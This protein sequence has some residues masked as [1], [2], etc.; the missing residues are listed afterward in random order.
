MANRSRKSFTLKFKIF[1][2][3][4]PLSVGSPVRFITFFLLAT[5]TIAE[6]LA[7]VFRIPSEH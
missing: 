5:Y 4:F 6:K 7:A 1:L 3:F 2:N